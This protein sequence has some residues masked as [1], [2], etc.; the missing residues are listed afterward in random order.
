MSVVV[1]LFHTCLVNEIDPEA[2]LAAVRLLERV[3]HR[4]EVPLEQTCCGQP[5]YN[6][7]FHDEAKAAGRHTLRV[8]SATAGP[9]VI[10][11]GSCGDMV[12]HQY[13]VLFR[14]EP[15]W[16]E[17]AHAVG[18][19]CRELSQF[20]AEEW[21]ALPARPR[22]AAR[23]AYHPSCHLLR[24]LGVRDAPL[25]LLRSVEG[26]TLA[27]VKDQDECCGFGGLFS[28]KQP[29]ISGRMLEQKLESVA[30]SGADRLVSCDLG[31]LLHLGGGLRRR[32]SSIRVQH[33]AQLLDEAL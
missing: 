15:E 13:E 26:V 4:V 16:L 23:V 22:L 29:E 33:L 11:S 30:A 25:A 14:D 24:G 7:G 10:P 12:I 32:G 1:Q 18:A 27:E 3:G 21:P 5:A 19:R 2:G 20:L 8:L 9:I 6:A 28:V 17:R 31:C